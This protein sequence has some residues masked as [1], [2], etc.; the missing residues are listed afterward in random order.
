MAQN[1]SLNNSLVNNTTDKSILDSST[2]TTMGALILSLT[3]VLGFPGNVFVIWSILARARKQSI[4]TLLILNL[5]IADGSLMAL[6]P[7]FIIYLVL[8][9]WVFTEVMCKIVFYL[10]LANMYASIHLIMLMSLY[11]LVAIVWPVRISAITGRRTTVR[12]L[13]VVWLLVIVASVP[14][15]IYRRVEKSGNKKV[16]DSYHLYD[17]ETVMQYMLELVLG[18]F[19]PYGV[20]LFSYICILRRIRQSKFQRRIRSEKLI[21]AIVLT[22]CLLWLPYHIINMVQVA[23]ALMKDTE[24]RKTLHTI[25]SKSRAVTS[26]IAFI[27]SSIN[28]ILYFF[29]G[30]SYIRREGFE[31]MARLFEGTGIDLSNR[32]SRQNSHNSREKEKEADAVM[33]KDKDQDSVTN[34]SSNAKPGKHGK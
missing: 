4:T 23:W 25:W 31:F 15:M 33:L 20:I 2:G 7:F 22:F 14:A 1:Y 24:K 29:A 16:C 12:M 26:S 21:L 18:C 10:C 6:T 28:P 8:K 9:N 17:S 3:F 11:R 32:K 19:I 5:A 34:S 13:A 30:K 27:S